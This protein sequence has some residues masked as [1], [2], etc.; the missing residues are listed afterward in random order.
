M[1]AVN[2]SMTPEEIEAV[3]RRRERAAKR[4]Q[5]KYGEFYFILFYFI[6][7]LFSFFDLPFK[8]KKN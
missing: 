2:E 7:F 1:I 8:K 4:Q 3:N 6:L 5:R